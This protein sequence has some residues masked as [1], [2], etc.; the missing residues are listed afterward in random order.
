MQY[1]A[2]MSNPPKGNLI[3][4]A[5]VREICGNVSDSTLYRWLRTEGLGFPKPY[6]IRKRRY[7]DVEEVRQFMGT[8]RA[9]A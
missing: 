9:A 8:Q 6:Y 2:D 1:E 3:T 4:S 7:W 5:R